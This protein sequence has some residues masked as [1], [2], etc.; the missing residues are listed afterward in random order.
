MKS[1]IW[2]FSKF[3][4][5]SI[6]LALGVCATLLVPHSSF[7]IQKEKNIVSKIQQDLYLQESSVSSSLLD[8]QY[9]KDLIDVVLGR[10][11]VSNEIIDKMSNFSTLP[12]TIYLY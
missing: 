7:L 5:L 1:R 8:R 2:H 10:T 4:L 9:F 12:Y 3:Q 11:P 6:F